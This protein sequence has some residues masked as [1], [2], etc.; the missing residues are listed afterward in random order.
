MPEHNGSG[1]G[2]TGGITRRRGA[3]KHQKVHEVRGHAFIAKFFRQPVFCS[4]CSDFLWGLN[5]Q[6]YQC[7]GGFLV[8]AFI[9]RYN[10]RTCGLPLQKGALL[11]SFYNKQATNVYLCTKEAGD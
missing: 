4:H 6:G 3:I 9:T 5:K 2:S 1:K 11:D 8:Y 7:K 10:T